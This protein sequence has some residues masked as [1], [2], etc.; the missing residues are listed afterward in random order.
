MSVTSQLCQDELP[1]GDNT[2]QWGKTTH[3]SLIKP[4]KDDTL[5]VY[6]T[7]DQKEMRDL[8][9]L[10]ESVE[11]SNKSINSTGWLVICDWKHLTFWYHVCP[12]TIM[13]PM[14]LMFLFSLLTDVGANHWGSSFYR[15]QENSNFYTHYWPLKPSNC[16]SFCVFHLT[17]P[18]SESCRLLWSLI[19][20]FLFW[21]QPLG[22]RLDS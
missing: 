15:H 22:E 2:C 4:V 9:H 14:V 13:L 12:L 10:F 18:Y 5:T 11:E 3:A 21:K 1:S 16:I 6:W 7:R 17:R 20:L 8:W 19:V